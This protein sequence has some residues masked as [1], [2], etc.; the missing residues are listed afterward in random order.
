M[1]AQR[2]DVPDDLPLVERRVVRLVVVDAASDVLLLRAR[3]PTNPALGAWWELP[4]GG[5][6]ADETAAEAAIRELREE[7]GIAATVAD[8]GAPTWRRDATFRY[9]GKRWLQHEVVVTVRLSSTAPHVDGARRV[10]TE[11]DDYFA[12]RW[13]S[14]DDIA[15]SAERF[16]PGRLPALV[17]GFL[18]GETIDEPY[19]R[20]S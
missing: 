2:W 10:G 19:E 9:R 3:D 12:D 7:A 13:W 4:G 17:R 11:G 18:R 14:V 8:V 20:W 1:D 5:I 6:E 16:Y 15:S